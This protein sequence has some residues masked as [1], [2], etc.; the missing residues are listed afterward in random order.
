MGDKSI[1]GT[2]FSYYTCFLPELQER[3][4]CLGLKSGRQNNGVLLAGK[5]KKS[6]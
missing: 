6:L 4:E 3:E 5:Y 2:R 1:P